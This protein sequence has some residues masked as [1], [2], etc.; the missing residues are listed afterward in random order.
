MLLKARLRGVENTAAAAGNQDVRSCW[1]WWDPGGGVQPH[2]CPEQA[3]PRLLG[4]SPS[5]GVRASPTQAAEAH[6]AWALAPWLGCPSGEKL[7]LV[8]SLS[9]LFL[10]PSHTSHPPTTHNCPTT[11]AGFLLSGT[12]RVWVTMYA[13]ISLTLAWVSFA[14]IQNY[15]NAKQALNVWKT[16]HKSLWTNVCF[17]PARLDRH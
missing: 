13:S 2:P 7:L 17:C 15:T 12:V 6:P 4:A 1:G 8:S 9:F 5:W 16:C 11:S 14:W 3:Y 10:S